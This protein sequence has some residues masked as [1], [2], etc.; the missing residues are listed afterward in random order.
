MVIP[1]DDSDRIMPG[2]WVRPKGSSLEFVRVKE[3]F[4]GTATTKVGKRYY[5]YPIAELEKRT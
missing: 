4:F 2:D 5:T 3:T 1:F